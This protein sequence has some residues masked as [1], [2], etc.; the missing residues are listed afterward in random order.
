VS[1]ARLL[2]LE[3]TYHLGWI[4]CKYKEMLSLSMENAFATGEF[5]RLRTAK[6]SSYDLVFGHTKAV[7]WV[8]QVH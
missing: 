5:I 6:S 2:K 3:A 4:D 1:D 7:L 8:V